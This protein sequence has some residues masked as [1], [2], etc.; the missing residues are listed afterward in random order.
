MD[1]FSSIGMAA[2][3]AANTVAPHI[4]TAAKY[5]GKHA[6]SWAPPLMNATSQ[7]VAAKIRSKE[8]ISIK[9]LRSYYMIERLRD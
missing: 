9:R 8:Q 5:A 7:L 3:S 1:I 6:D 4:A 2:T